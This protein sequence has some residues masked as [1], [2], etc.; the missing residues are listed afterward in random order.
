MVAVCGAQPGA[1]ERAID[2]LAGDQASRRL[3]AA[4]VPQTCAPKSG[5]CSD[6]IGSIQVHL[7]LVDR[8]ESISKSNAGRFQSGV[9]LAKTRIREMIAV[10]LN[11]EC[12]G[13]TRRVRCVK[14]Q[15]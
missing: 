12:P 14:D 9:M 15:P 4:L 10:E 13:G 1:M 8:L 7:P 6:P 2:D 11:G 5:L 3:S